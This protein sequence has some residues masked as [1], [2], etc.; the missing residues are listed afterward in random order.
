MRLFGA[1]SALALIAAGAAG[2]DGAA[3]PDPADST[4]IRHDMQPDPLP[5]AEAGVPPADQG[6]RDAAADRGDDTPDMAPADMA[7]SDMAPSDMAPSDMALSDGGDRCPTPGGV[8]PGELPL[9]DRAWRLEVPRATAAGRLDPGCAAG[10]GGDELI[11]RLL[12]EADGAHLVVVAGR[13]SSLYLTDPCTPDAPPEA[14]PCVDVDTPFEDGATRARRLELVAGEPLDLVVD[15]PPGER[16]GPL[17]V[18]VYPPVPEGGSC[19]PIGDTGVSPSCGPALGCVDE[20]CIWTG[21]PAVETARAW[22][23]GQ[24][25]RMQL[26]LR[27]VELV[28]AVWARSGGGDA[29]FVQLQTT[30][31]RAEPTRLALQGF[32]EDPDLAAA[33]MVEIEVVDADGRTARRGV[34][35]AGLEPLPA[36]AACDPEGMRDVCA[37][38]DACVGGR[39]RSADVGVWLGEAGLNIEVEMPQAPLNHPLLRPVVRPADPVDARWTPLSPRAA[40]LGLRWAASGL[41]VEPEGLLLRMQEPGLPP[42]LPRALEAAPLP[43]RGEGEPCDGERISDTCGPELACRVALDRATCVAIDPPQILSAQATFGADALGL[44]V[45]FSDLQGDAAFFD[46]KV[47]RGDD[48]R[49]ALPAPRPLPADAAGGRL[50][51]SFAAPWGPQRGDVAEI[52]LID[53][54]GLT[55]APVIAPLRPAPMVGVGTA[56]DPL[57]AL[58]ACAGDDDDVICAVVEA[59]GDP[60]CAVFEEPCPEAWRPFPLVTPVRHEDNHRNGPDRTA[61]SCGGEGTP[62]AIYTL[63]P[64]Q[65]ARWI[66]SV[67]PAGSVV[68]VRSHCRFAVPDV[69]EL[70]CR[71]GPFVLDVEGG[72]TYYVFVDG[73]GEGGRF[74]LAIDS[75]A[76][77]DGPDLPDD[78]R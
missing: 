24:S 1:V 61:G 23:D 75:E 48:L 8:V 55:S 39:C 73:P 14:G 27:G 7:P 70:A 71:N 41:D 11:V 38:G 10:S 53:A 31:F 18:L 77:P 3:D 63:T 21:P 28:A 22:S 42:G 52:V 6:P 58:F 45:A 5:D 19:A 33:G 20:V 57:G 34:G 40:E 30:D 60:V 25:L 32:V 66:I 54:E 51:T 74:T 78:P 46:L 50:Q 13:Y 56:C 59:G 44:K 72:E 47:R 9:V 29:P 26:A 12:P 16:A 17:V 36:D 49:F 69:S 4:I 62:E 37:A 43:V 68:Y 2:C 15:A 64:R 35:V 65:D 76:P 67:Q